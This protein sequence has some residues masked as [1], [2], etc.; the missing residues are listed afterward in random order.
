M[1]RTFSKQ[2]EN[3][4]HDGEF[5]KIRRNLMKVKRKSSK[6]GENHKKISKSLQIKE[7]VN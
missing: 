7:E 4:K 6:R 5:N 1:K 2:G 3:Q